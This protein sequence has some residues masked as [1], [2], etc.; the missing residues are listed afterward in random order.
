MHYEYYDL[1]VRVQ[2]WDILTRDYQLCYVEK[3]VFNSYGNVARGL[4][5][6]LSFALQ[7]YELSC[8]PNHLNHVKRYEKGL[9]TYFQ[10]LRA[11]QDFRL[12]ELAEAPLDARGR[13]GF[14]PELQEEVMM[15]GK[16]YLY[17]LVSKLRLENLVGLR[18]NL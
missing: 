14:F 2:A 10:I 8:N 18:P 16:I 1:S 12:A 7:H 5:A 13:M 15:R 6:G 3:P 9:I 17:P 4:F 11:N